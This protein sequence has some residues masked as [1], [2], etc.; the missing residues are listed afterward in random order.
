MRDVYKERVFH[1]VEYSMKNPF[2]LFSRLHS[3]AM[4]PPRAGLFGKNGRLKLL[5]LSAGAIK[6][7]PPHNF[8]TAP[9][10]LPRFLLYR[11]NFQ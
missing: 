9:L 6:K 7:G 3:A 11:D 8:E 4:R 2:R 10:L 1:R 5:L